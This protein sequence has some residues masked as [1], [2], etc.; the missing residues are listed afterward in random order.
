MSNWINDKV[1]L[2]FKLPRSLQPLVEKLEELDQ[3]YNYAYFNYSEALDCA[4][5]ELVVQGKL[6]REQWDLLCAKYDVV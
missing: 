2:S 3:A 6:T 1:K 4:A 5:K